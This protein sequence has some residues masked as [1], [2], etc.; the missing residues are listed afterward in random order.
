MF[1]KVNSF[2]AISKKNTPFYIKTECF[3]YNPI[4]FKVIFMQTE[5]KKLNRMSSI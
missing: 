4:Y 2:C 1:Q 5:V 3:L